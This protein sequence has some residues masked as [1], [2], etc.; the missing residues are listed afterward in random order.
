[1]RR[2]ETY[3]NVYKVIEAIREEC[4]LETLRLM[5]EAF[6]DKAPSVS[7]QGSNIYND[8]EVKV[9]E[10]GEFTVIDLL[11]NDYIDYI[12]GGRKPGKKFP[13]SIAWGKGAGVLVQWASRKG[14]GTDNTTI[15]FIWKSII[16]NGIKPRPIINTPERLWT[17]PTTDTTLFSLVSK[18]W[19]KWR[20][21]IF[22]AA[23]QM[24]TEWF[25][26]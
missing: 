10:D 9:E 21:D 12:Q 7:L 3:S 11:V 8:L 5:R 15:Y 16:E 4:E 23:C 18:Y 14:L 24:L 20:Q 26:S 17:G 1:M 6:N 22:D 25:N 19:E 13:W 2:G